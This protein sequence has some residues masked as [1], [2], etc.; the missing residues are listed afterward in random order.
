MKKFEGLLFATDLDGTLL[1]DDKTISR[2]NLDAI[3]YFKSEG[4]LFTFVTGRIPA[5]AAHVAE[6]VRPNAPV[7]CIQGGGL[8]DYRTGELLWAVEMSHEVFDLVDYITALYST[9]GVE[10]NVA[11]KIYFCKKNK[12]TEKHRLD[13]RFDD[14]TCV[15]RE[16]PEPFSKVLIVDEADRISG[17]AE[18]LAAHPL[19][20]KFDFVRSDDWYYEILVKGTNKGKG[21]LKLC[22]M[23]GI[24]I[25]NTVAVGD[26]DNDETL[27]KT[28]NLSYAVSNATP[29]AKESA[30]FITVSNNESAI[31]KVIYSL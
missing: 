24:D 18:A 9:A 4:G 5:G 7:A 19:A 17:V 6:I 15:M 13:E 1:S 22:D 14:L 27:L 28:A 8:F 29:L 16:V 26:N 12:Y 31:A 11:D 20:E 30:K 21:L 25:K 3:E 2:E 23:L 10:L